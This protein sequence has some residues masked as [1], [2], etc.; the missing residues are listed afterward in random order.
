MREISAPRGDYGWLL[1]RR[2]DLDQQAAVRL[3]GHRAR[4]G[5]TSSTE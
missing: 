4:Q 1:V 3:V 2:G 5:T